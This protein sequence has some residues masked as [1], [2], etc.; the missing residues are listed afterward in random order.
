MQHGHAA[1]GKATLVDSAITLTQFP[2]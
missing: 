2:P 1:N